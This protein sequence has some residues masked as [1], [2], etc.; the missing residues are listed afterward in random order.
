MPQN[1]KFQKL[2]E[3]NLALAE[4]VKNTKTVAGN[5]ISIVDYLFQHPKV[6]VARGF[7]LH[8]G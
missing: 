1:L 3:M 7:R 2:A 6:V 4:A 5:N 8:N